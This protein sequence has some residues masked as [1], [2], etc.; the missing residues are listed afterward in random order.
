MDASRRTP[1]TMKAKRSLRR[2]KPLERMNQQGVECMS[3]SRLLAGRSGN[4]RS[5]HDDAEK[6]SSK[7][8]A[9]GEGRGKSLEEGDWDDSPSEEDSFLGADGGARGPSDD[10][11]LACP[12]TRRHL[13]VLVHDRLAARRGELISSA[14]PSSVAAGNEEDRVDPWTDEWQRTTED[15]NDALL[16][17]WR[18]RDEEPEDGVHGISPRSSMSMESTRGTSDLDSDSDGEPPN[19]KTV[20]DGASRNIIAEFDSRPSGATAS[21][22]RTAEERVPRPR[23]RL[24]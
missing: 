16:L 20:F 24:T 6:S 10:A 7:P 15:P 19:E 17:D 2:V 13:N 11:A 12:R 21:V 3:S 5:D 4:V 1:T 8:S 9:P 22:F 18:S 23:P 14:R